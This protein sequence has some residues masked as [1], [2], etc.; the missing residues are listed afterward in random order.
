[1][2]VKKVVI[3]DTPLTPVSF[4]QNCASAKNFAT[5]LALTLKIKKDSIAAI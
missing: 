1:M 2:Y 3:F 4:F 5:K